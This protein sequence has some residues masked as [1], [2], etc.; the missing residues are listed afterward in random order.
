MS[1][2]NNKFL[3]VHTVTMT[4]WNRKFGL[5]RIVIGSFLRR[6]DAIRSCA[7]YI[8]ERLDLIPSLRGAFL[9]NE[10]HKDLRRLAIKA[11]LT[12]EECDGLFCDNKVVGLEIP[13]EVKDA[14]RPYLVD[15]LGGD[16]CFIV[17]GG[18]GAPVFHFDVDE[19]DVEG[20]GGLQL[21]TCVAHGLDE[22]SHEPEFGDAHPEV[23]LSKAA[24]IKCAVD[25]LKRFLD[26]Y[27]NEE[28]K[29]IVRETREDLIKRG[30]SELFLN[31]THTVYWDIWSTP[32]NIG[33]GSLRPCR[34]GAGKQ[35]RRRSVC[36]G[37]KG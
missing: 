21:W 28:V 10:D 3:T 17:D 22:E 11:G 6:G 9:E 5:E 19:N 30:H 32:V 14:F 27:E 35:Q 8:L 16:G 24:A 25:D 26:G 12:E 13:K 15:R 20:E 7:D 36:R 37:K 2:R 29:S 33:Q 18:Y 4:E 31:D 34:N 23:F 1:E